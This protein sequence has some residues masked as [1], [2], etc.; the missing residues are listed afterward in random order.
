MKSI[1][2]TLLISFLGLAALVLGGVSWY[3]YALTADTLRERE[4]SMVELLMSRHEARC[5]AARERFD[6]DLLRKAA[7][8]ASRSQTLSGGRT[9][10]NWATSTALLLG[11][12]PLGSNQLLVWGTAPTAPL[13]FLLGRYSRIV[14]AD[15][16]LPRDTDIQET[17]Y[18][19]L[20]NQHFSP[21]LFSP[22][23]ANRTL[24]A[25]DSRCVS[26]PLY[27]YHFDE[28]EMEG[29][30][31]RRVVHKAVVAGQTRYFFQGNFRTGGRVGSRPPSEAPRPPGSSSANRSEPTRPMPRR[32]PP[33]FLSFAN[34][35]IFV[36]Y[37]RE[38]ERRDQELARYES[39]LKHDLKDLSLRTQETLA[40][41]RWRLGLVLLAATGLMALGG[42]YLA[43]QGL[44][45]LHRLTDAVSKVSEK[46]FRLHL[47]LERMPEELVPIV[48]RLQGSLSSLEKAF[49]HEKQAVAD[50]SHELRTPIASL[51]TTIQVCLRK[52]RSSEEYRTALQNCAEI[53]SHL[54]ELVQRLLTLARLDAGAD[55]VEKELIDLAEL[56]RGCLEMIRPLA[57]EKGLK[58]G[59]QLRPGVLV[60]S[61]AS[62]LREI[63]MNLLSN[64]VQ[65]NRGGGRLDLRIA[66]EGPSAVL[67]V[68]D[69][70]QGISAESMTHL[71][72]RFYRADPSRHSNVV[73]AGLGLAIVKGY[74]DLLGGTIQVESEQGEGS[75]FRV[76]LPLA[77]SM[78]ELDEEPAR[79]AV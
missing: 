45:P 62:K 58:V 69:T 6:E 73:H 68:R 24:P 55:P 51:V 30:R 34:P 54:Q 65:Y 37:A 79:L 39:D 2:A 22:T 3:V 26:L 63:L 14:V 66:A 75:R 12:N 49:A 27:E 28:F 40:T 59:S 47:P 36:Q 18:C 71:F 23:L 13:H 53:G 35:V 52:P 46:D 78:T 74:V 43:R 20:H 48:T 76:L 17:E 1:R 57:E 7:K 21:V 44:K 61:D 15:E 64:A 67:E 11:L 31:V 56:G 10:D 42:A 33:P 8:V 77:E 4:Q 16:L 50:I 29:R 70:G 38:T 19:Q 25:A 72:E 60:E 41:L 5:Q 32:E 9:Q